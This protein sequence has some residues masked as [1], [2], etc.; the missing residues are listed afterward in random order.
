MVSRLLAGLRG[1]TE[2]GTKRGGGRQ[3]GHLADSSV[4]AAAHAQRRTRGTSARM[5]TASTASWTLLPS[6]SSARTG[7]SVTAKPSRRARTRSSASKGEA[8]QSSAAEHLKSGLAAKALQAAL[9]ITEGEAEQ[10]L[11]GP[12]EQP[13]GQPAD[14]RA[15]GPAGRP[16]A[17]GHRNPLRAATTRSSCSGP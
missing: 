12:V 4:V 5:A 17:D 15:G 14:G 3:I 9:A 11:N 1:R 6:R 8:V 2:F 16:G 13:A 7:T 10:R